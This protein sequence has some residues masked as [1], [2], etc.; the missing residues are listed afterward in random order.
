MRILNSV[1]MIAFIVLASSKVLAENGFFFMHQGMGC[2]VLPQSKQI[3]CED[4]H[5]YDRFNL[6]ID[7]YVKQH[8][9][10]F[11]LTN[12]KRSIRAYGLKW[13]QQGFHYTL[14]ERDRSL[15]LNEHNFNGL[16]GSSPYFHNFG[17]IGQFSKCNAKEDKGFE[18]Q[19]PW[20]E[21]RLI[22]KRKFIS[23]FT[24]NDN[25]LKEHCNGFSI[26]SFWVVRDG[27]KWRCWNGF[28]W[29]I[30][31]AGIPNDIFN[32]A[33]FNQRIG[34]LQF[35]L[36]NQPDRSVDGCIFDSGLTRFIDLPSWKCSIK[37]LAAYNHTFWPSYIRMPEKI[38]FYKPLEVDPSNLQKALNN[39]E[40][41]IMLL[42]DDTHT[43][44]LL[45]DD[46]EN[47]YMKEPVVKGE[48][49]HPYEINGDFEKKMKEI[50][51]N[52]IHNPGAHLHIPNTNSSG[53]QSN[54]I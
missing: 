53:P 26:S 9:V 41:F 1:F 42:V 17:V 24:K 4:I 40:G 11:Q 39:S 5:T 19:F 43:R 23:Y 52:A 2:K 22:S 45:P 54:K 21:T 33:R 20:G 46:L 14:S 16:Y 15:T 50:D 18:C 38:K 8:G 7:E 28:F 51:M 12:Q 32:A 36:N 44:Y 48:S 13:E 25:D 6:T 31:D 29:P 49:F 35:I 10:P 3:T 47:I 34:D 27:R 37:E 30:N